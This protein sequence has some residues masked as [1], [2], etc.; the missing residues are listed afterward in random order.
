MQKIKMNSGLGC[1]LLVGA[2]FGGW[3]TLIIA[4]LF[5]F[6]FCEEDAKI[7]GVATRVITFYIAYFLVSYGWD[8]LYKTVGVA[9]D[10][11]SSLS[12]IINTYS[13]G[14]MTFTYKITGPVDIILKLGDSI[15]SLLL[16]IAKVGFAAA[17]LFNK[18][19]KS[20]PVLNK[21]NEFVDKILSFINSCN[22]VE[23]AQPQQ[24]VN[25][26]QQQVVNQN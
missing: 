4:V 8:I 13:P 7:K 6:I 18:T 9:S 12:S 25:P 23:Q 19:A 14:A 21:I 2:M 22:G 1:A 20:T 3:E 10:G 11:V 15:V 17:V 16:L 24:P 5:L 26:E